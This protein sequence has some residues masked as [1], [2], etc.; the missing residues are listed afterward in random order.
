MTMTASPPAGFG[1]PGSISRASF[2]SLPVQMRKEAV[3][4]LREMGTRD[5]AIGQLLGM[6]RKE[7]ATLLDTETRPFR[8]ADD[9]P[10]DE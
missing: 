6:C 5:R 8:G 4:L 7:L 3:A 1:K 2:W 10:E 9:L